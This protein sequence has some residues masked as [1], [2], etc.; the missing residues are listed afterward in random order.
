MPSEFDQLIELSRVIGSNPEWTQPGGGNTSIKIETTDGFGRKTR[1]LC[2]KGSG[3][4]LAKATEKDFAKLRLDDLLLL[5]NFSECSD[6]KMMELMASAAIQV[7][8]APSVE[9]PLHALLPFRVIVHTHDWVSQ[10]LSNTT[11]SKQIVKDA[12]GPKLIFVPYA[13]PGFPLAKQVAQLKGLDGALGLLLEHHGFVIW[14]DSVEE[15][16]GRLRSVIAQGKR[17]L[18]RNSDAPS[19]F[20]TPAKAGVQTTLKLL[21]FLRGR[22]DGSLLHLEDD[23]EILKFI[24]SRRAAELSQRGVATPEHI[25][26]CGT[27]PLYVK[28]NI[29][30]LSERQTRVIV[31][32]SLVRYQKEYLRY[33]KR[34]AQGQTMLS[35]KPKVLLLPGVGMVTAGATKAKAHLAA[36]CYRHTARVLQ[37]SEAIDCFSFLTEREVFAVDYWSLELAKTKAPKTEFD[38]KVVFVTGAASGIGRATALKFAERGAHVALADINGGLAQELAKE[39]QSRTKDTDC[40]LAIAMNVASSA[41]IRRAFETATLAFGGVDILVVNAGYCEPADF[42]ELKEEIWDRHFEINTKAAMLCSQQAAA[43]FKA[44]G[45][46]GAILFN[47]SK[48]ALVPAKENAAYTASK[49]AALMLARNLALELAPL[50][51]R[52]NAVNADFVQTPLFMKL[53]QHRA[54]KNGSSLDKT[55]MGYRERN[56]LKVGPIEPE[57]VAEAFAYLASDKARYTTGSIVTVDGGLVEA[58]PR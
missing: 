55:L 28:E 49:A 51:V 24:G 18:K 19:Y 56:L 38:R 15:C 25:L 36:V 27:K 40:A 35:P 6:E 5:R 7:G 41:E 34:H 31:D 58:M 30:L 52:V 16:S 46:G 48:A 44:Q 21:P 4:D 47:A 29:A 54:S 26:R 9:T 32:R 3:S 17:Y 33:F 39:I 53:A 37:A 10:A 13:R 11:R 12:F 43:I 1:A 45:Y 22:L 20:V 23:Q 14:G 8:P 42:F 50:K 57:A 2:V